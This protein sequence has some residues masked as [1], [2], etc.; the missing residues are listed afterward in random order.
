[1][2]NRELLI[3]DAVERALRDVRAACFGLHGGDIQADPGAKLTAAESR[4]AWLQ[5]IAKLLNSVVIDQQGEVMRTMVISF[6]ERST[7]SIY[8]C[9]DGSCG[10]CDYCRNRG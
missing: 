2:E 1:M 6:A 4:L 7:P 5:V 8:S 3:H 10:S 9:Q